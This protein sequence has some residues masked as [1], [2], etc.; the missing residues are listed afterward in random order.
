L[1]RQD[2]GSILNVG[3]HWSDLRG[4]PED[5]FSVKYPDLFTSSR[6]GDQVERWGREKR[7]AR[8]PRRLS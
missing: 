8:P 5:E 1:Q 2:I 6:N 4:K 7:Q 3:D